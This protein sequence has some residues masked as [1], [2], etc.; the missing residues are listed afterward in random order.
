MTL[1]LCNALPNKSTTYVQNDLESS[2]R[3]VSDRGMILQGAGVGL[4][5]Y[6]CVCV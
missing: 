5:V 6:V 3:L 4:C 2:V 1:I